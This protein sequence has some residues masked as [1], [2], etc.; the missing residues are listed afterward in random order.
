M[1]LGD[2]L[3]P[4]CTVPDPCGQDIKLNC[5]KTSI[6]FKFMIILQNLITTHHRKMVRVNV[7]AN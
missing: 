1:T 2:N 7:T 3:D 5:L 4:V 6:T